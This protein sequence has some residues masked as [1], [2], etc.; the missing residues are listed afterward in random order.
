MESSSSFQLS[1][2]FLKEKLEDF[3]DQSPSDL[4]PDVTNED[5]RS[6]LCLLASLSLALPV[7]LPL[8][9]VMRGKISSKQEKSNAARLIRA[10]T[11]GS[12]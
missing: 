4:L 5:E 7:R 10:I 1:K 9:L 8:S 2:K 3:V 11:T 6:R 12:I